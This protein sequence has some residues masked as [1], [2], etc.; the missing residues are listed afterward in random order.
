M[1]IYDL[2][3]YFG[4]STSGDFNWDNIDI[5]Q[6][7]E[8]VLSMYQKEIKEM[9]HFNIVIA[10]KTGVGK[11]TLVNAIFRE[12]V[13]ETGMGSPVSKGIRCYTKEEIPMR[14]YDT[15]GLEL[16]REQQDRLK[17]EIDNLV[18]SNI[19]KGDPDGF[20]HVVWYCISTASD[21][22]EEEELNWID[23]LS[24][25][26]NSSVP[27]IVVL[28]KSYSKKQA[29]EMKKKLEEKNLNIKMVIPVLAED[30]EFDT[31]MIVS[32]YGLEQLNE[33]TLEVIPEAARKAYVNAQKVSVDLKVQAARKVVNRF[34]ATAMAEGGVPLPFADAPILIATQT[35]MIAAIT[36]VFGINIDKA[37]FAAV[38]S[39]ILGTTGA[40][41]AGRTAVSNI[42]KL[43]PGAGTIIGGAISA[44][45]ATILTKALGEAYIKLMEAMI[46][47]E[48]SKDGL[49]QEEMVDKVKEF[50]K[51]AMKK[52][53]NE[54]MKY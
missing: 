19:K 25:C 8:K 53:K 23:K 26:G 3:K 30:F 22:I 5:S 9:K 13:A 14:L 17:G 36:A 48:I 29:S 10:G 4:G 11:S 45:T 35:G 51:E 38:T 42:L 39:S 12:D 1:Y 18:D 40:T 16:S 2:M 7:V 50:F 24:A 27:V 15:E 21:R 41:I 54:L 32:A 49:S 46:K 37:M 52:S 6:M 43:L 47:G 44:S 34:S 20:I 31:D 33:A 28:T